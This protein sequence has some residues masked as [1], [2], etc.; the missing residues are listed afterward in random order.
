MLTKEEITSR[1]G[2]VEIAYRAENPSNT[3]K[4]QQFLKIIALLIEHCAIPGDF[5]LKKLDDTLF[6]GTANYNSIK[7]MRSVF[8]QNFNGFCRTKGIDLH[9]WI[10]AKRTQPENR[11]A[12]WRG[13]SSLAGEMAESQLHALGR[14]VTIKSRAIVRPMRIFIS[15]SHKDNELRRQLI[16]SLGASLKDE[17]LTDELDYTFWQFDVDLAEYDEDRRNED[18]RIIEAL[19]SSHLVLA[20]ISPEF[21]GSN[22]I[23]DGELPLY[24]HPDSPHADPSIH[25]RC[26]PVLLRKHPLEDTLGLD[27][28]HVHMHNNL[29]YEELDGKDDFIREL[30]K[31]IAGHFHGLPPKESPKKISDKKSELSPRYDPEIDPKKIVAMQGEQNILENENYRGEGEKIIDRRRNYGQ[32]KNEETEK[33]IN[34][35]VQE[36]LKDW[37]NS[38]DLPFM[39]L[40]GDY[41]MGKTTSC[42]L[43]H[44]NLKEDDKSTPRYPNMENHYFFDLRDFPAGYKEELNPHAKPTLA[45]I[46]TACLHVHGRDPANTEAFIREIQNNLRRNRALVIFDGLDEVLVYLNPVSVDAFIQQLLG[47]LPRSSQNMGEEGAPAFL[48]KLLLSCRTHFFPTLKS[49]A[50]TLYRRNRGAIRSKDWTSL[51]LLPFK[52]E[53]I[54]EYFTR[55]FPEKDPES[56]IQ[57]LNDIHD[58]KG[59]AARPYLL[60]LLSRQIERLENDRREGRTVNTASLYDNFVED[61]LERDD[62]KHQISKIHKPLI[63]EALAEELW[64]KPQQAQS[65]EKMALWF[66]DFVLGHRVLKNRYGDRR[67]AETF[68]ED[69]RTATFIRRGDNDGFAFVH[70]SIHEY[71]LA[72]RLLSAMANGEDKPWRLPSLS[73]ET[74]DFAA[75][76]WQIR[77]EEAQTAAEHCEGWLGE[78]Q[79]EMSLNLFNFYLA[80]GRSGIILPHDGGIDL[81]NLDISEL[82]IE[83]RADS[84][85]DLSKLRIKGGRMSFGEFKYVNFSEAS[86]EDSG[87]TQN[88]FNMCNFN[89]A[90]FRGV[91]LQ[92][93]TFR[94]CDTGLCE[95]IDSPRKH[96]RQIDTAVAS[97]AMRKTA[98]LEDELGHFEPINSAVFSQDSNRAITAS[99]DNTAILWD[100]QSGEK[101]LRLEGHSGRVTSAVFSPD[102]NRA[103]TSSYDGTAIVWDA[104]SGKKLLRLEGHSDV[105]TSAFFSPDA[106][107]ALTA[108]KDNTAILWDTQ[109]GKKL[110]CLEGHSDWVQSAVF[111]PDA[112]RALTASKDNTAILWDT[113]SGKKIFSLEGHS[114]G[115]T[116]A[117]FSPDASR[118]L[119]ASKDNTAIVWDTKSGKILFHLEGHSSWVTS[120]VFSPDSNRVITAS[121][122]NTAILWDTKSG[123]KI[124]SLEGHSRGLTSAVFSPDASRA[125]T[126]SYDHTAILWDT[127]TGKKLLR[128]EGHS[129]WVASAVFSP[130]SN[131]ALTA[132]YDSTAILWDTQTGKKLLCLE[133]YSNWATSTVFS[134]D[135]TRALTAFADNTAILWDTQTGKKLFR[136]EGHS[137]WVSRAVFSP[138]STRALTASYDSTTILWDTQTGKKLLRLEGH[139]SMVTS[140]VFSPDSSRALTASY[141]HTAILWDIQSG[142]ELLRLEGHS[143]GVRSAVF[144]PNSTRVLTAS[145]DKTAILW[146]TQTGKKLLRLEGHSDG[147][148]SAVFSPDSTRALTVSADNTAILWDIQTG[149]K[150]LRLE[151]HSSGVTSAV[152]SPDSNRALTASLDNT[153][154]LW[155]TQTGKKLLRLEGHSAQV[156]SAV[157]SPDSNR[158]LTASYDRTTIVWDTQSGKPLLR[159]YHLP[160]GN[161]AVFNYR[162]NQF[163]HASEDAWRWFRWRI[164]NKDGSENI[165]PA[166]YFGNLVPEAES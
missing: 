48:G 51:L 82:D 105:L 31:R 25:I 117:V 88:L 24:V 15:T 64:L 130:D 141:D 119:T 124:F 77:P 100:T 22:Y 53:Q 101:L 63:M 41:G 60:G 163:T 153:A 134:P 61:W 75:D 46:I 99:A 9:L 158:A 118:A 87:L 116:S 16:S 83:G 44:K 19:K 139:S 150:L 159:Y 102:S 2:S 21:M 129:N 157:F 8:V 127:Q 1:L 37:L 39:A 112:S 98:R 78:F 14:D 30:A 108:S 32:E 165:V 29:S 70:R 85:F 154:I 145:E 26:I 34:V 45:E 155:D 67:S 137:D 93:S 136:L 72:R 148:R 79:P 121:E 3:A 89:R 97:P 35:E 106:S 135:S 65:F 92:G 76:L 80:V 58:L 47:I 69:L 95:F 4:D 28:E 18:E 104:H 142:K 114:R 151:G 23:R 96:C 125:L 120:A 91:N 33:R 66:E 17:D 56:F 103:I 149:K 132:S 86:I 42:R 166:E 126:A 131:R 140:A 55:H 152:F 123:K 7:T 40:L 36:G 90:V 113:K 71:F 57:I 164:R 110:L 27:L 111:S 6:P 68:L 138:D 50:Q 84:H 81:G 162:T 11:R 146:D 122:D 160:K 43:L 107:R 13:K 133:G 73:R 49:Q 128:L 143:D 115:L 109:T 94:R 38:P 147:V 20:L 52:E 5:S 156:A 74:L 62:G 161:S 144:S 10:D 54:R 12:E 59:L